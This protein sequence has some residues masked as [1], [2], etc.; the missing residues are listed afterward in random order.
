MRDTQATCAICDEII[1]RLTESE[2]TAFK[3][4]DEYR[5]FRPASSGATEGF[6]YPAH[7]GHAA[8]PAGL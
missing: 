8:R 3:T 1:D 2:R 6:Y 4:A 5:H 7:D